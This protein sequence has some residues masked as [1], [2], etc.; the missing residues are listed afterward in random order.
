MTTGTKMPQTTELDVTGKEIYFSPE[1]QVLCR[2]FNIPYGNRPSNFKLEFET[3]GAVRITTEPMI[4]PRLPQPEQQ[5]AVINAP[6]ENMH[7]PQKKTGR[8]GLPKDNHE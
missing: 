8:M 2:R 5:S 7:S 3:H 6:P 4:D 1:F